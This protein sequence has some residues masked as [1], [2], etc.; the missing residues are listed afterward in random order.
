LGPVRAVLALIEEVG[1][2]TVLNITLP[3]SSGRRRGNGGG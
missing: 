2:V 1:G 3:G